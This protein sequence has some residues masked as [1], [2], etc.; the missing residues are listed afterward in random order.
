MAKKPV[1]RPSVGDVVVITFWDHAENSKDALKFEAIGRITGSTRM[2]Y[3][4]RCWGYVDDVDRA[5]DS[6]TDNENHYAIVKKAIESIKVL[7]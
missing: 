6:N 2:A 1:K 3:S 7:K 4:V 5:G